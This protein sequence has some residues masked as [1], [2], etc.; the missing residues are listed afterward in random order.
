MVVISRVCVCVFKA[1]REEH[2]IL[3]RFQV[4]VQVFL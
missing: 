1:G 4:V 3:Q 2:A